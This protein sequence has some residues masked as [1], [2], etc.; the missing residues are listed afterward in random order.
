MASDTKDMSRS[1]L[2]A[3][4]NTL[5]SSIEFIMERVNDV[6]TEN[7]QKD[8]YIQ[9]LKQFRN[10]VLNL[11]AEVEAANKIAEYWHKHFDE[12][13]EE[14]LNLKGDTSIYQ[15]YCI[16]LRHLLELPITG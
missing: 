8:E 12:Q 16:A 6:V 9:T 4:V 5:R 2:E 1:V 14:N 3:E 13:V 11:Q 7:K 10:D 15:D